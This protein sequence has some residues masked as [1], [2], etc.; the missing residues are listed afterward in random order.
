MN[1]I[2]LV[3]LMLFLIIAVIIML[4]YLGIKGVIG[5]LLISFILVPVA[6][7]DSYKYDKKEKK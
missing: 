3:F 1:K 4:F 2:F 7:Y 5:W 6:M